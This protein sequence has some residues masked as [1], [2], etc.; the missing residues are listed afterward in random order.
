MLGHI[1]HHWHEGEGGIAWSRGGGRIE[2][3]PDICEHVRTF[4]PGAWLLHAVHQGRVLKIQVALQGIIKA[5]EEIKARIIDQISNLQ[6]Q[7]G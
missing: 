7:S 5:D 3:L 4:D 1:I 6:S 2:G